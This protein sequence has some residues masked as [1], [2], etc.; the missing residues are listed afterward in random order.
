MSKIV[1]GDNKWLTAFECVGSIL[2]ILVSAVFAGSVARAS[3]DGNLFINGDLKSGDPMPTGWQEFAVPGCGS[4]FV[5]HRDQGTGGELEIIADEPGETWLEQIVSLKGGWYY[6]S[7]EVQTKSLGSDGAGPQLFVSDSAMKVQGAAM[8]WTTGWHRIG[9]YFKAGAE[10]RKIVL[11][12]GLG[13]WGHPNTGRLSFRQLSLVRVEGP[14]GEG[15]DLEQITASKN[16]KYSR[17]GSHELQLKYPVGSNWSL[18]A[19]YL[20]FFLIAA[21]GWRIFSRQGERS[22]SGNG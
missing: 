17:G 20:G 7:A 10:K 21:I 3:D 16:P 19:A 2:L 1:M 5:L 12:C 6:F 8:G 11:G 15:Y 18:A 13:V 9:M 22:A 4:R 14:K